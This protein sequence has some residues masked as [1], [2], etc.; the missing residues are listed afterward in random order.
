MVF[1]WFKLKL[2]ARSS[3]CQPEAMESYKF[4][5]PVLTLF[6]LGGRK[7]HSRPR[8]HH[9]TPLTSFSPITSTNVEINFQTFLS[10]ELFCY[11]GVKFQDL[12]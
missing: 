4:Q 9:P 7:R 6:R 10:F 11:T 12:S 3:N 8:P 1:P 5:L 2:A